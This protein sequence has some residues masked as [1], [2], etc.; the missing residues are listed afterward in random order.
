M[1]SAPD[2]TEDE[3]ASLL[4]LIDQLISRQPEDK[5]GYDALR[6]LAEADVREAAE[7]LANILLQR[8]LDKMPRTVGMDLMNLYR[9]KPE[10]RGILDPAKDHLLRSK[11]AI[12][13]AARSAKQAKD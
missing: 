8:P 2:L 10:L 7:L 1:R 6:F 5:A 4:S 3:R 11:A 13:I 12:G 9:G